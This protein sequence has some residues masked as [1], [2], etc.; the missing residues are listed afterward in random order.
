MPIAIV[1]TFFPAM[2]FVIAV[3]LIITIVLN[4]MAFLFT[5]TIHL[6]RAREH[7]G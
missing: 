7:A 5:A 1:T 6:S 3:S 2:A 4:A